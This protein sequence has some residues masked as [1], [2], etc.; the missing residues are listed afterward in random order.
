MLLR[1]RPD[2]IL[3]RT[4]RLR[5]TGPVGSVQVRVGLVGCRLTQGVQ[6][7]GTT[8]VS[9]GRMVSDLVTVR[10]CIRFVYEKQNS[11]IQNTIKQCVVIVLSS[12]DYVGGRKK[13]ERRCVFVCVCVCVR[14]V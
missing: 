11:V 12:I 6:A 4:L 7:P 14:E 5:S 3:L 13:R 9:T 2:D 8:V 1:P 10:L